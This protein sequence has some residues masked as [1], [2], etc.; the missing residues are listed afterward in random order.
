MS[1]ATYI[2]STIDNA[3]YCKTNGQ[4]TRHLRLHNFTY[5]SYYETYVSGVTPLCTCNKPLT[6]YQ[7]TESYA[8][9]CGTSACVGNS[10]RTTK[11]NWTE[12][13]RTADKLA[14]RTAATLK[15]A[16]QKSTQHSKASAT[17]L[18]KYGVSW[19][20]KSD[21]QKEKSRNT[22]LLKYGT[23][24]YNNCKQASISRINRSI[25]EKNN[26]ANQRRRTNLQRYGIENV[27]LINASAAKSNKGNASIKDFILP[28]GKLIGVRGFEP[29][30]ITALLTAGYTELELVIH[31]D[32]SKYAIE[33]FK[34]EA[35]NRHVLNYYP[36]I[37]IPKENKIIEV[38]SQWWWDGNNATKY[39]SRLDNNL[40]KR[41]S[42]IN[43]GYNY[44]VWIFT[45]KHEYKVLNDTD[46]QT[47]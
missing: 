14:K 12:S 24:T 33:I 39:K 42:V 36:D 9:S 47:K 46:F 19:V 7:K 13:Q 17:F 40:R 18:E 30:A 31:D 11:H 45:S 25:E 21:V 29:F 32:Y 27:L 15:T 44:E 10:I 38:K 20:S 37:Y 2:T 6:F 1:T 22:K 28:S 4:F 3:V 23:E 5:K 35:L 34:Y 43:R 8:N 16:E 26:S 41:Q